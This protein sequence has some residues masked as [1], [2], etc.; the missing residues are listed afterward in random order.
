[1]TWFFSFFQESFD[2]TFEEAV[3]YNDSLDI[4][5]NVIKMLSETEKFSDME[6]KIRK[7]RNKYKQEP[8]MWL[9]V[10]KTYYSLKKLKEARNIK[11]AALKSI[12]DRKLRKYKIK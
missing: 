9:E 1:M 6:E 5:L 3:R 12:Q 2:K 7:V 10:A 4:Y 8:S 11:E